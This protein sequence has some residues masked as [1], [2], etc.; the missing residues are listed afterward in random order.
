MS[1]GVGHRRGS[2]LVLLWLWHRL[3]ATAPIRSLAWEPSYDEGVALKRQKKKKKKKIFYFRQYLSLI[4]SFCYYYFSFSF[5]MAIPASYGSSQDRGQIRAAAAGLCRSH[6]HARSKPHLWPKPQP[7]LRSNPYSTPQP[8][9]QQIWDLSVTYSAACSKSRSLTCWARPG[10]EPTS[11][12][13]M[14]GP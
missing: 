1:F 6:S 11:S 5:F 14:S 13:T 2:D 12:D 9:Q 7:H 3:A 8:Q 4:Y 10:I